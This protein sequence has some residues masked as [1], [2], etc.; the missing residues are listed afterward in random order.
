[1]VD[2]TF[3]DTV[4]IG[5]ALAVASIVLYYVSGLDSVSPEAGCFI[6]L[7]VIILNG[8]IILTDALD[9]FGRT[10]SITG[11]LGGSLLVGYAFDDYSSMWITI[12]L[13]IL[14]CVVKYW[15]LPRF[16]SDY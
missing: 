15:I 7:I 10:I 16:N 5:A 11:W 14:F 1:M 2:D 4:K 6:K 12:I 13:V 3:T 9:L 8:G